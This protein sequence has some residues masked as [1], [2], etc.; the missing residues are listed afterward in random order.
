MES[1]LLK[2]YLPL[3]SPCI[4]HVRN[5]INEQNHNHIVELTMS[6]SFMSQPRNAEE[7]QKIMTQTEIELSGQL[8]ITLTDEQRK[9][10][11]YYVAKGVLGIDDGYP[12]LFEVYKQ[13]LQDAIEALEKAKDFEK[14]AY[15]V[16][17]EDER[18]YQLLEH[19]S[20]NFWLDR[21]GISTETQYLF[22]LDVDEPQE[23]EHLHQL[24]DTEESALMFGF[25]V[26][27]LVVILDRSSGEVGKF[28]GHHHL[29]TESCKEV[30]GLVPALH[31]DG[32]ADYE[33]DLILRGEMTLSIALV[34][35]PDIEDLD[36]MIEQ[37]KQ[38]LQL[39]S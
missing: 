39:I 17:G 32:F 38:E 34:T 8:G 15:I 14:H 20:E 35:R 27:Q 5:V 1:K 37:L 4:E 10:L 2:H 16:L 31:T 19:E 3:S 28:V 9:Q 6:N 12:K 23:N 22:D 33:S 25:H 18:L 24:L 29:D 30:F 13:G 21:N 26:N 36:K 7:F 11:P